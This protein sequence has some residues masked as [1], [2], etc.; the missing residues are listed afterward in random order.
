MQAIQKSN[1]AESVKF[2]VYT[3]R[4]YDIINVAR[5]EKNIE[6]AHSEQ[7]KG[8]TYAVQAVADW[9]R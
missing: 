2:F 3:F 8:A 9:S 1:T 4:E 5:N 6:Q 7:E